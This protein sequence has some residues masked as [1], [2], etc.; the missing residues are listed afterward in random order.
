M[1]PVTRFILNVMKHSDYMEKR[2]LKGY[3][4]DFP[5]WMDMKQVEIGRQRVDVN[6][7]VGGNGFCNDDY[8]DDWTLK[9]V[10]FDLRYDR[11][12]EF[13]SKIIKK[14]GKGYKSALDLDYIHLFKFWSE[15]E[16]KHVYYVCNDGHR[17]VSAARTAGIRYIMAEVT[18]LS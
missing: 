11:V 14:R 7:I 2:T 4:E 1:D 12:K 16:G 13:V 17:R 9:P 5:N 6:D 18:S 10:G 8:Y 15:K 3:S